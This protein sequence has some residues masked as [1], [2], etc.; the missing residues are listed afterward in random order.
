MATDK[1]RGVYTVF[2]LSYILVLLITISSLV[3]FYAQMSKE[4][5]KEMQA[6]KITLLEQLSESLYDKVKFADSLMLNLVAN[7]KLLQIAKGYSPYSL[8]DLM[9]EMKSAYE[10]DYLVNL[11]V[12]IEALNEIVTE[13]THMKTEEFFTY[14]YHL[15]NLDY[16][17]FSKKYLEGYHYRTLGPVVSVQTYGQSPK[18]VLPYIQ[19][20]PLN[21]G[22]Q[23]LGQ[24]IILLDSKDIADSIKRLSF[25]TRSDV[26]IL[27]NSNQTIFSSENAPVL[28]SDFTDELS[29]QSSQYQTK[30]GSHAVTVS[31][32]TSSGNGWKYVLVA[33]KTVFFQDNG[34]LTL[35]FL[36]IFLV[37]LVAGLLIVQFLTKRSYR[38]I[39]E[40]KEIIE[41]H[42]A[43]ETG[44]IKASPG[45][46]EFV[47]IKNTILS[48]FRSDR[49]LNEIIS[50]QM[51]IVRQSYLLSLV[52]GL[53]TN[54][55]EAESRLPS[56]GIS[57]LSKN[58]I[59]AVV[60]YDMDS[61]F[62]MEE[63]PVSENTFS[64]ANALVQKIGNE[65][66]RQDGVCYFL[67]LDR[68]KIAVL[69]NPHEKW[70]EQEAASQLRR[71][72]GELI[73]F[74]SGSLRLTM[75]VGVSMV[76]N[77]IEGLPKC[78]DEASKA[79][80]NSKLFESSPLCIYN[81]NDK[82]MDYYFSTEM[83]YQ[84]ISLLKK[85]SYSEGKELLHNIF[86][87]NKNSYSAM[88]QQTK[89]AL[90][91]QVAAALLRAM[92]DILASQNKEPASS[93]TLTDEIKKDLSFEQ[94]LVLFTGYIDKM[95]EK[96]ATAV[97]NKTE[98]LVKNIG[99]FINANAGEKWLDLNYLSRKFEITPQYIS[100]IFKKY[101]K[102][103]I[104]DYISRLKLEK[105]K[106]LLVSTNL[107]IGEISTSLGYVNELGIFRLFRKYE[108]ITP[109]EYRAVHKKMS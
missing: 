103:N 27:D 14:M 71:K 62:F 24:V 101:Q 61:P 70:L 10:P 48:Q 26:Y 16:S 19:S 73:D 64:Y 6:S 23:T 5:T 25:S 100:K 8:R 68:N 109:G 33:P 83:E 20:F 82:S 81:S 90:Y 66:S 45:S 96:S 84:L 4:A 78:F 29:R 37:Y 47:A 74:A 59:I 75:N 69:Y 54:Y 91:K 21:S 104:K 80:E 32:V 99:A 39:K 9:D 38:P 106:E 95:A 11:S 88:S 34:K 51:P 49:K 46:N 92:N 57:L 107:P 93:V 40:I 79:L 98:L 36:L 87:I 22:E 86:L 2:F 105:A 41:V 56:L 42:S 13:G 63:E 12:H 67:A 97:I 1:R 89:T 31:R 7:D 72:L 77:R 76:H 108:D 65:M 85:G 18:N 44:N 52:K 53:E 94:S 102:E 15:V 60:E 58:F 55:A 28:T 30:I 17:D 50:E 43:E 35:Q 3:V